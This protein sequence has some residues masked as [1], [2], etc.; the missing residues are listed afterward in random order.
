[1]TLRPTAALG[2]SGTPRYRPH[3]ADL[4]SPKLDVSAFGVMTAEIVL[5]YLR[6]DSVP[7]GYPDMYGHTAEGIQVGLNTASAVCE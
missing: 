2:T 3:D 4:A 6:V 5:Q 7:H 1:M